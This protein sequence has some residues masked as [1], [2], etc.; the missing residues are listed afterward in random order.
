ME[1][2]SSVNC[3]AHTKGC[4][5]E[6]SGYILTLLSNLGSPPWHKKFSQKNLGKFQCQNDDSDR[7][8]PKFSNNST[9]NFRRALWTAKIDPFFKLTLIVI[10][11]TPSITSPDEL[12]RT[13]TKNGACQRNDVYTRLVF[14]SFNPTSEYVPTN[15]TTVRIVCNRQWAYAFC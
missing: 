4:G 14:G 12:H 10:L 8:W 2:C 1:F 11:R 5:E 13:I 3:A 6:R 15:L 9:R 7:F